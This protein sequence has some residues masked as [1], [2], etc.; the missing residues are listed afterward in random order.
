MPR[1]VD[2][3]S[4]CPES[5]TNRS[6][7]CSPTSAQE[8]RQH[9][10]SLHRFG[11]AAIHQ[12]MRSCWKSP[13]LVLNRI[14]VRCGETSSFSGESV[15]PVSSE[16]PRLSCRVAVSRADQLRSSQAIRSPGKTLQERISLRCAEPPTPVIAVWEMVR[17]S[18]LIGKSD[19]TVKRRH[20][21]VTSHKL[22]RCA[23]LLSVPKPGRKKRHSLLEWRFAV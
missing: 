10:G 6:K 23:A 15:L 16:I 4:I 22:R 13:P 3:R 20:W 17:V 2:I 18:R 12:L 1:R 19:T 9:A 21:Q 8:Y 14:E 5:S 11:P 7:S